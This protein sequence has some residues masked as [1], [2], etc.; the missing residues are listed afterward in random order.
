LQERF[1]PPERGKE[2]EDD[3]YESDQCGVGGE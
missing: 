1:E 2:H 3:D